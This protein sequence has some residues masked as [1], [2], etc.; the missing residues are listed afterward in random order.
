MQYIMNTTTYTEPF[1]YM[2][3]DKVGSEQELSTALEEL[4]ALKNS[5][6]MFPE[7]H[8]QSGS[9]T[10][11]QFIKEGEEPP[12]QKFLKKNLTVFLE[13]VKEGIPI[14]RRLLQ[15]VVDIYSYDAGI[16]GYQESLGHYTPM[17]GSK[18]SWF[19]DNFQPTESI[20]ALVSYYEDTGYYKAHRDQGMIT[21]ISWIFSEPK[22]FKG[23]NLIFTDYDINIEVE[24]GK[25][26]IFPSRIRHEVSPIEMKEQGESKGRF[27]LASFAI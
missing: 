14:V 2:V 20:G 6:S 15:R 12:S 9:A 10:A 11:S 21:A 22:K 19:F 7:G 4:T 5:G 26:V 16:T 3:I 24:V 23:G 1:H 27:T 18:P 8:P 25:A 13:D 17:K